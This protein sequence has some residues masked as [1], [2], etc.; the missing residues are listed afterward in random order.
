M[1][2]ALTAGRTGDECDLAFDSTRHHFLISLRAS[3]LAAGE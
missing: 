3:P 2:A 1:R